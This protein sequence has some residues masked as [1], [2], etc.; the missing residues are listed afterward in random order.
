MKKICV[1]LFIFLMLLLNNSKLYASN[2]GV[3]LSLE[4]EEISEEKIFQVIYKFESE[5]SFNGVITQFI[6]SN[7]VELVDVDFLDSESKKNFL[8]FS[9]NS[10]LESGR[11]VTI[12]ANV[13]DD[14]YKG[15]YVANFKLKDN[16]KEGSIINIR[17]G[18]TTFITDD[19]DEKIVSEYIISAKL[20]NG[21][22]KECDSPEIKLESLEI[23][24]KPSKLEYKEGEK[25]SVA[26]L[27]LYATYDDGSKKSLNNYTISPDRELALSDKNVTISYSEKGVTKDAIIAINVSEKKGE[28]NNN[29][30]NKDNAKN[31]ND[32]NDITTN[33]KNAKKE[34]A[35]SP[36]S[37]IK[38]GIGKVTII[39]LVIIV[40]IIIVNYIK[41]KK[42]KKI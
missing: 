16:V 12:L 41:V 11:E 9:D 22:L 18:D 4:S 35:S 1:F 36:S 37:I 17:L 25:F 26:G 2:T 40:I 19:M 13:S 33:N 24:N 29:I 6:Y 5:K 27:K 15:E 34:D 21:K 39:G 10:N 38:A 32:T 30:N 28:S 31:N 20:E 7:N 42:Y 3:S 14:V 8:D 23:K